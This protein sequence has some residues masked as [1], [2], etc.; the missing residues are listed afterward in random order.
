MSHIEFSE[1]LNLDISLEVIN[2][3]IHKYMSKL[4]YQP[5]SEQSGQYM[6]RRG[7]SLGTWTSF[8]PRKWKTDVTVDVR[9]MQDQC[10]VK[11]TYDVD[12]TGQIVLEHEEIYLHQE[13]EMFLFFLTEGKYK[14]TDL[15]S[16]AKHALFTNYKIVAFG[17]LFII[18]IVLTVLTI[19][20]SSPV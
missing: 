8:N 6:F 3:R 11:V 13:V 9:P 15:E 5:L 2:R 4:G 1:T 17:M 19:L 12:A 20:L 14:S 16:S 10:E 18:G 7:T